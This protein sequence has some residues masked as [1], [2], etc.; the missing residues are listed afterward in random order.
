MILAAIDIGS[1]AVRLLIKEVVENNKF[2]VEFSKQNL[3][4]IPVRLGL[5]VFDTGYIS[6]AKTDALIE[7]LKAFKHLM[8]VHQ[9][10][11]F[12]ICATAALRNAQN[13]Q[14]V[15]LSV[16]E[17]TELDIEIIDGNIEADILFDSIDTREL[18]IKQHSLYIDVGGGSTELTLWYQSEKLFS[19][20]FEV[21]TLRMLTGNMSSNEW[22]NMKFFLKDQTRGLPKIIAI[23]SGGNIN[24]VFSLAKRKEG[25]I[26]PIQLLIHYHKKMASCNLEN[27]ISNFKLRRDRADV[28]VPALEIYTSVMRW[29]GIDSMLVPQMGLAD[30]MIKRLYNEQNKHNQLIFS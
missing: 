16:K 21:G 29:T 23:G 7:T 2:K 19:K 28:I 1:N 30:G 22:H 20:S 6:D 10:E 8:N 24:K 26:L 25:D 3:I 18:N 5:D 15:L 17:A 27:R 12:K 9:V 14:E 11:A 4:R 13:R